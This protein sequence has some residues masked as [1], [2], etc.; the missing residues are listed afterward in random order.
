M[1]EANGERNTVSVTSKWGG[2]SLQ[3]KDALDIFLFISIL[4]LGGLTVFEHIGRSQEHDA[5]SCQIKLNLYMQTQ[6]NDAPIDWR[7]M[8]TDL[9]NCIPRFLYERDQASRG[10]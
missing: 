8:P 6:K 1:A 5:I 2:L 10:Q 7:R 3:G 4:A 9:Y